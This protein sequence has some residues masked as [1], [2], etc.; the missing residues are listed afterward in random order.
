PES[1]SI[2]EEI[3]SHAGVHS[4]EVSVDIPPFPGD[5]MIGVLVKSRHDI[6]SLE[7]MSPLIRGMNDIRR[8][9]WRLGVY[10]P[11]EHREAVSLAATEVF[12]IRPA[13]KQDKL[14]IETEEGEGK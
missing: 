9:Q 3:A 4:H 8:S 5:M 2:A 6:V 1:I 14:M 10:C 11:Q 12:K 13:T 7:D